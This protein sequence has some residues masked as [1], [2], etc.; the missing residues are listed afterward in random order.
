MATSYGRSASDDWRRLAAMST[1]VDD[2]AELNK[3]DRLEDLQIP[4]TN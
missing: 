4:S 3:G 2:I 1:G